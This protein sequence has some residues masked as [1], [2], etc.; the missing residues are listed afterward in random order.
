[1][2][3]PSSPG[4]S[5]GAEREAFSEV[6]ER[7]ASTE[8]T[9]TVGDLGAVLAE[10]SFAVTILFLMAL[11]ALPLPTGGISHLF[12]AITVVVAG[13]MV[14]GRRSLWLP[15]RWQRRT[16]GSAILDK[17]VPFIVRGTRWFERYARPRGTWVFH[18]PVPRAVVG[19]LIVVLAVAAALSPP[20]SGL[21]TIPSMG[22]VIIALSIIL[23]DVVVLAVG[24]VVGAFGVSIS[25]ALGAAVVRLVQGLF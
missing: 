3:A 24:V 9:K 8:G 11:P 12:E 2:P 20:F 16:L 13:Q 7:W 1:V 5:D 25:V 17:A 21:D 10:K 23:E 18:D 6:L 14:L 4:P 19:L 22:A 15:A